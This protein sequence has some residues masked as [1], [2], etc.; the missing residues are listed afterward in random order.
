[1]PMKY[2]LTRRS[3][4]ESIGNFGPRESMP[5]QCSGHSVQSAYSA[6]SESTTANPVRPCRSRGKLVCFQEDNNAYYESP[7]LYNEDVEN[8]WYNGKDMTKFNKDTVTLAKYIIQ[9]EN[10]APGAHP[11]TRSLITAYQGLC[12]VHT[13]QDIEDVMADSKNCISADLLGMEHWAIPSMA[14]HRIL[15][16]R[17]MIDTIIRLQL[18]A[19]RSGKDCS[20]QMRHDCRE[21][22]RPGRLLA[23][24]VGKLVAE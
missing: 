8:M 13:V 20:K 4:R 17:L 22:S 1:M 7:C 3:L 6:D 19:R 23:F 9:M 15:R 24:H 21:I 18:K 2:K 11:W 16:R 5:P 14:H 12:N 10:Q